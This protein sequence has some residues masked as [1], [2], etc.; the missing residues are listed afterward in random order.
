MCLVLE[1]VFWKQWLVFS[2]VAICENLS[3]C[4]LV[5]IVDKSAS[6]VERYLCCRECGPRVRVLFRRCTFI[7]PSGDFDGVTE[8]ELFTAF[9]R[10][11]VM[12]CL[13][14][15]SCDL[16]IEILYCFPCIRMFVHSFMSLEKLSLNAL[17]FCTFSTKRLNYTQPFP[18]VS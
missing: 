12:L 4:L 18:C 1:M 16:L 14:I 10:I 9:H 5:V 6:V 8:R 2:F 17:I 13:Q 15:L 11:S 7:T 3:S